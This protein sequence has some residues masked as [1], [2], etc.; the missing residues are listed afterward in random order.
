MTLLALALLL[1]CAREPALP[2]PE[3]RRAEPT[4]QARMVRMGSVEGWIARPV[5]PAETPRPGQ[6]LLVEALDPASKLEASRLAELGSV[7]LVVAPEIST[8]AATAY[9]AGMPDVHAVQTRCLRSA[10]DTP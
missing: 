7:V 4:V 8:Q 6:L 2:L 1:G 3:P 9:L 5:A 10:C